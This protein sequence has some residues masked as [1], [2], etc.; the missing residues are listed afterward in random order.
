LTVSEGIAEELVRL[1]AIS[2]PTIVLNCPEQRTEGRSRRLREELGIPSDLKIALFQGRV[3][4]GRSIETFL[5][6]VQDLPDT[7]GVIL[8]DGPL[9]A[10]LRS[11]VQSGDWQRV[12]LPGQVPNA[13]LLDYTASADVGVSLGQATCPSH[14]L[15]LP[16]KLFEYLQAGI[17]IV[18][19]DLPERARLAQEYRIGEIVN[20]GDPRSIAD[21]LR[22]LL[23]D[24]ERYAQAR[25]NVSRAAA[26]FN[27]E[28]ESRKLV[29]VYSRFAQ[30]A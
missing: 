1:Y 15:A 12:Y 20:P 25:A 29:E 24:P 22:R 10:E 9:L 30:N 4:P 13:I 7:A 21:G 17:P 18:V 11:R 3:S 28:Q 19:S 8:G 5:E 27:W 14:R 6:A 16:N 2:R 26:L 23:H